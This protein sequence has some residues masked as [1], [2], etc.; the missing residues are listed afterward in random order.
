MSRWCGLLLCL[1]LAFLCIV[2]FESLLSWGKRI[3]PASIKN[4]YTNAALQW[5]L[6]SCDSCQVRSSVCCITLQY[7]HSVLTITQ[8]ALCITQS[9]SETTGKWGEVYPSQWL[10]LHLTACVWECCQ[11]VLVRRPAEWESCKFNV[12]EESFLAF[13]PLISMFK[14]LF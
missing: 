13:R 10:P 9:Q 6:I 14:P 8:T 4:M 12:R 7:S 3:V 2:F 5:A 1:L 11:L